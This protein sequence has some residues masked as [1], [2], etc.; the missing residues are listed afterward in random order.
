VGTLLGPGDHDGNIQYC[1]LDS[2]AGL[3]WAGNMAALEIHAPMARAD[4]EHPTMCVFDLDPGAPAGM[5]ECA[6]VALDLRHVLEGIGLTA[7]PKT[8]GS[9]GMQVYVPLNTKHTHEQCSQF[10]QAAAQAMERHHPK[11]VVSVMRK[12][13]RGGKV[14]IDWS[15]NSRHKTTIAAYSL[16]ARP[17]P[18]VSTPVAWDEVES[19]ADGEPLSF[20]ASDVLERV[21]T[22]GDLFEATATLKQKLPKS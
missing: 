8:S 18:T 4:I 10:A 13:L 21:A 6:E 7:F 12:D 15:Q 3:A 5:K 9:K 1:N 2:V 14:F 20:E 11:R 17:Q 19:A 22:L 16:R